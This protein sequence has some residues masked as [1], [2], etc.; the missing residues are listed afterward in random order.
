M[1]A[2]MHGWR[3]GMD[4]ARALNEDERQSR[5]ARL[6]AE[7]AAALRQLAHGE[8]ALQMQTEELSMTLDVET[9][10]AD[11]VVLSGPQAGRNWLGLTQEEKAETGLLL[12]ESA[13]MILRIVDSS[14]SE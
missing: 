5:I 12:L 4:Q 8:A 10:E 13:V 2:A 9:G 14:L 1:L 3:R 7:R 6:Q 11:A